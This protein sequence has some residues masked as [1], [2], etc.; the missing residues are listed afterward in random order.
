MQK[1]NFSSPAG[2]KNYYQGDAAG[3]AAYTRQLFA[4]VAPV[5]PLVTRLLSFNRDK[6]WKK[7][8]VRL[9]PAAGP[10]RILD[11]ACGNGDITWLLARRYP[12]A[13]LWGVDLEPTMLAGARRRFENSKTKKHTPQPGRVRF[14]EENMLT[15]SAPDGYF[16]LVTGGYALRNAPDLRAA[17]LEVKRVLKKGGTAAFLDFSKSSY[18]LIRRFQ[19]CLLSWWGQLWGW[20]L[21]HRPEVYGYLAASLDLFPD[22]RQWKQL[23][24][25]LG[26]KNIRTY[27]LG[28]GFTALTFITK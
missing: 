6:A 4:V 12:Q 9:L 28:G 3:K 15:L 14:L 22:R 7:K 27:S 20:L 10:G 25:G 11:L 21:H 24:A 8:L 1:K 2:L 13:E 23:L 19:L 17:L 16:D 5:Y 18:K 26:F